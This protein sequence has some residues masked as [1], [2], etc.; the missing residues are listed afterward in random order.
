MYLLIDLS[1]KDAIHLSL[2]DKDNIIDKTY[3]GLNKDLLSCID[4][5]LKK[6]VVGKADVKGIIVVVGTGG[7]TSTRIST[8]VGNTM[9]YTL[10]IP[11]LA[12]Q[13][14]DTKKI[15]EFTPLNPT[16]LESRYSRD[17]LTGLIPEL[18][19]Q[20]IGQYILASYSGPANITQ[21]KA[22]PLQT[23]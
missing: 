13:E 16:Q 22:L 23:K 2:F 19:D 18:L 4:S 12:L 9:A 10:Q 6:H 8:V 5:L 15:Q 20:P 21:P 14:K 1:V 11:I 7:F 17:Y 3:S